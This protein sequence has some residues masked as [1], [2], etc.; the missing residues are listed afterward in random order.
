MLQMNV[1]TWGR[2]SLPALSGHAC[3]ISWPVVTDHD[4]C[5]LEP[6]TTGCR[7]SEGR[8]VKGSSHR[9]QWLLTTGGKAR[10]RRD[11][12]LNGSLESMAGEQWVVPAADMLKVPQSSIQV[13]SLLTWPRQTL[14]I[15]LIYPSEAKWIKSQRNS[16]QSSSPLEKI[17]VA[18]GKNVNSEHFPNHCSLMIS[19]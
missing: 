8:Q 2:C 10:S 6:N 5:S 1:W 9:L 13:I 7:L 4:R 19:I 11:E 15:H 18:E 16:G 14:W 12:F 17:K 3:S